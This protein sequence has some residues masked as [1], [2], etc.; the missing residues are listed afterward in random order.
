MPSFATIDRSQPMTAILKVVGVGGGGCNAVESMI[1]RGLNGVE[2]VAVNTDA[3]V[4]EKSNA[5]H[6]IQI[7]VKIT[8]GL[9]AGADPKI[10][11]K[12]AEED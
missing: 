2:Y 1:K 8:K 5:Q 10:G 7:G 11:K 6:K 4:L 12:A 3:Q 9:G